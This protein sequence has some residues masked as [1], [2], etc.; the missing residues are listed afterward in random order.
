[1]YSHFSFPNLS[2]ILPNQTDID[3]YDALDEQDA[4]ANNYQNANHHEEHLKI[5]ED[6]QN[7]ERTA[8][9]GAA[10]LE[11]L[12]GLGDGDAPRTY[13]EMDC[14]E[15]VALLSVAGSVEAAASMVSFL[16]TNP[17]HMPVECHMVAASV[18][19]AAVLSIMQFA[20]E[21]RAVDAMEHELVRIVLALVQQHLPDKW[22]HLI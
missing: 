3:N 17:L 13:K 1:M 21:P 10:E 11:A 19:N 9:D 6:D 12:C 7:S 2:N 5:E 8:Q 15:L 16:Q 4:F 18:M 22:H 14:S 20:V